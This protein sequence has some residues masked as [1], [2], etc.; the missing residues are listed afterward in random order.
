[1]SK[2]KENKG[3]VIVDKLYNN[4]EL[5]SEEIVLVSKM[6]YQNNIAESV[7]Y[8]HSE[9]NVLK[10]CGINRE[11]VEDLNQMFRECLGTQKITEVSKMIESVEELVNKN[12]KFLRLVI[13]QCVVY[14]NE[15][16]KQLG[17]KDHLD[18]L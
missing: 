2:S 7:P 17:G 10:A 11:D 15:K 3:G 14:A 1:M 8:D 12:E 4:I 18:L 5:S 16:Q 6:L 13:F 9:K